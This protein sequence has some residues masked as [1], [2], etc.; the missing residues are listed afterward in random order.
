MKDEDFNGFADKI[1]ALGQAMNMKGGRETVKFMLDQKGA[2]TRGEVISHA[3]ISGSDM[4][5]IVAALKGADLLEVPEGYG[6]IM[7]LS[8]NIG[9][10]VAAMSKS[11][12]R[13]GVLIL[14]Q[15]GMTAK[16]TK[17]TPGD[18]I[19]EGTCGNYA[20]TAVMN[21]DVSKGIWGVGAEHFV[22]RDR[23]TQLTVAK[24][25]PDLGWTKRPNSPKKIT[26][27]DLIERL[28]KA[29]PKKF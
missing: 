28:F 3:G 8:P 15:G 25:D 26:H 2:A 18:P 17:F 1:I 24:H 22:M 4:H 9:P 19:V 20:F 29:A 5:R 16:F 13:D 11:I 12:V 23:T 10:A 21:E 14:K 7:Y 27:L 6:A